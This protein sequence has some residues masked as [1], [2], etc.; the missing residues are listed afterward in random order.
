M[1][2]IIVYRGVERP[3]HFAFTFTVHS[4]AEGSQ[5]PAVH[6]HQEQPIVEPLPAE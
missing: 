5:Q 2:S 3:P 6:C 1:D 4:F